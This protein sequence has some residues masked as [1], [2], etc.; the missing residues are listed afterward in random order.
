[1]N[2][3][4]RVGALWL[5]P[6]IQSAGFAVS[7]G[8]QSLASLPHLPRRA[9]TTL[10]QMHLVGVKTMPVALMVGFF[11]GM[12]LALQVGLQLATFSQQE[13]IGLIIAPM[14]AI[15][16]APLIT[17]IILAA[18]V[19]S[20]M[21]AE[22]GTMKVQ[23]ELTAL[24]VLS[25]NVVSYLVLPRV[26]A[27]TLMS[28]LLVLLVTWVATLGGGIIA[29]SQLGLSFEGYSNNSIESMKVM[30]EWIPVPKFLF[31]GLFKSMIF[32][33]VTAVIGCASGMTATNG[34]QGVGQTT[35]SAVRNAIVLIIVLDFFLGKV[36]M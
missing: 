10:D 33:F 14:M 27:L 34:A 28:P 1:M 32:G 11:V 5:G 35:R 6:T 18:S 21:A 15:E 31:D 4:T 25:V 16:M 24:N 8:V 22:L 29:V 2:L 19:G 23:E 3:F 30:R 26:I 12:I 36:L 20:A 7:I 13:S 9:R 17:A